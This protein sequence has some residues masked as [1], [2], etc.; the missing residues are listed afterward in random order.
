MYV[1]MKDHLPT[2]SI[3]VSSSL[4]VNSLMIFRFEC[5]ESDRMKKTMQFILEKRGGCRSH[6]WFSR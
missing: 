6:G 4:Y 3:S 1:V 2:R 5:F